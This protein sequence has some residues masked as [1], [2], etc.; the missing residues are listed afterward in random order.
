MRLHN[1]YADDWPGCCLLYANW[2][3]CIHVQF[4]WGGICNTWHIPGYFITA[5]AFERQSIV[6]L[7]RKYLYFSD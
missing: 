3:T 7:T 6:I 5:A 4:Y 1:D 2:Y